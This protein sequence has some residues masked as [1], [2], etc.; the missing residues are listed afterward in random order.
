MKIVEKAKSFK[1]KRPNIFNTDKKASPFEEQAFA[2]I[3]LDPH[4]YFRQESPGGPK[5]LN[6]FHS[7]IFLTASAV[8][9]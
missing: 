7:F 1:G 9:R 4:R 8:S 6:R 3:C 5:P 2:M